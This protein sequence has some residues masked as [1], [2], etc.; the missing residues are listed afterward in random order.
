MNKSPGTFAPILT[1]LFGLDV[2][3]L[4]LL[5]I[6]L[7]VLLLVDLWSRSLNLSAHYSDV[8][9]LPRTLLIDEFLN[10]WEWSIH[11]ISGQ[12]F[13]QVGLFLLA[14]IAAVALLIG[15]RTQLFVVIS[16]ILLVSLH[17]RNGIVLNRGDTVF[18]VLL[19]WSMFLPLGAA[20]SVDSALDQTSNS[21][22][23]RIFSAASVAFIFQLCFVYWFAALLKDDYVWWGVG[24]DTYYALSLD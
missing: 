10:P 7:A 6:C 8:G 9:V 14:A 15:Y 13:F 3:S 24:S 11:L 21:R 4:A 20:Y 17:Y 18:R 23:G 19:F 5:R 1:T 22:P 16:W 2:R 12:A